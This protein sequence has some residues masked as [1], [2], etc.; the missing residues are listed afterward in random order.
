MDTKLSNLLD[1]IKGTGSQRGSGR[2]QSEVLCGLC[3]LKIPTQRP[4][5]LSVTSVLNLGFPIAALVA[6]FLALAPAARAQGVDYEPATLA[7]TRA[8]LCLK[9][10]HTALVDLE[11]DVNHLAVLSESCR[12]EYG[13]KA[14]G[15]ATQP[16]ASDKPEERYAY[17]VRRPVET[18]SST[19]QVKIERRNWVPSDAPASR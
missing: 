18:H 1:K 7:K 11:S 14:C 6:V 4:L 15:L 3:A 17:Y 12:I 9:A 8:A 13:A 10:G 19:Q 16:L 2:N 5:S